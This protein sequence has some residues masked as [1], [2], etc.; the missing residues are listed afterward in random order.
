MTAAVRPDEAFGQQVEPM[1]GELIAHC[2]RMLG[3]V[4]DAEDLVQ[5]SL[6]R[7]W[8]AFD[9]FEHRSSVRTW[10]YQIA[11]NVCLTALKQRERRPL[12]T[13]LG[14]PAADPHATLDARPESAW[15][16]PLPDALIW[17][18][19]HA[20]AA[21]DGEAHDDPAA[22]AVTRESVRLAF[23]AALQH[24]T[25]QQRAVVILRDV[26]SWR[27]AEV[28]EALG[29][30]V[31]AVNSS[32]QR[33]RSHLARLDP[34]TDRPA[35]HVNHRPRQADHADR[36]PV[37]RDR[38]LLEQYVS[39]FE[40]YDMDRLVELLTADAVWEMPPF[41]GWYQGPVAI[42]ELI[43]TRCPAEGPADQRM[44]ATSAN[45]QPTF[46]LYM[47][48]PTDGVH[49]AFQLQQLTLC[50]GLVAHVTAYFD[51]TLFERFGLP[52]V[53]PVLTRRDR[54]AG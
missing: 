33:A 21:Q 5:E 28:A 3:S 25:A 53:Y 41:T 34:A 18:P 49:R 30:S 1:R 17:G 42:R 29:I 46:A 15:L 32:L 51:L 12:P 39:A 40:R 6:L 50:D 48:D 16:E 31:A 19:A 11:T 26:L 52:A 44:L 45:G 22:L 43:H 8:R 4:G 35:R 10:L 20:G 54:P 14:Q 9:R 23:V 38:R 13:G 2:Y 27:A 36:G 47:R 24:L 37:D 7:A